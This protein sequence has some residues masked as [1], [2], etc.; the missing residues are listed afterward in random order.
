MNE[1]YKYGN[2]CDKYNMQGDIHIGTGIVKVHDIFNPLPE[3]MKQADVIFV[4]PPYN[5]SALSSYYTKSGL[6]HKADFFDFF[7]RLFDCIKSINPKLLF[8]ECSEKMVKKYVDKTKECYSNVLVKQS[9]YYNDKRKKC[10]IIC[11][12]NMDFDYSI[13]NIPFADEEKII[14]YICNNI[15]FYCI[16]DLCMGKGLVAFYANK[17]GKKFVGTELNK[18]RLAVCLERVS[19]GCR[20]TIN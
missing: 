8:I 2:L 16:G 9:Y 12:S 7:C 13:K 11:A 10:C 1:M 5:Q 15:D 14:E 4:D 17:A 19:T 6:I 3:F 20:G 18:Y